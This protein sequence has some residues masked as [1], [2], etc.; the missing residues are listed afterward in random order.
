MG[1]IGVK[2]HETVW[3]GNP[4]TA[5]QFIP[6]HQPAEQPQEPELVPAGLPATPQQP[7]RQS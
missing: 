1:Q 4:Q 6:G 7:Q 3:V 2:K 5:P